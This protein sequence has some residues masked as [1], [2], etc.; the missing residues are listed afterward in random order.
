MESVQ[1]MITEIFYGMSAVFGLVSLIL[2]LDIIKKLSPMIRVP[3][4]WFALITGFALITSTIILKVYRIFY[5]VESTYN[6]EN[7]YFFLGTLLILLVLIK[8]W[9]GSCR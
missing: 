7:V 4:L 1:N 3:G 5:A 2:C 8:V 6:L 9:R